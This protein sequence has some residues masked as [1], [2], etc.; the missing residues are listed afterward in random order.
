MA[1][2]SKSK[3]IT[4]NKLI[5]TQKINIVKSAHKCLLNV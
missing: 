5:V 1:G 4:F 3:L 2:N